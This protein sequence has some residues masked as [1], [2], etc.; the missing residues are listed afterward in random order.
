MIRNRARR[1]P[2]LSWWRVSICLLLLMLPGLLLADRPLPA[3]AAS[4]PDDPYPYGFIDQASGAYFVIQLTAAVPGYGHFSLALPGIGLLTNTAPAQIIASDPA[5]VQVTY[6]GAATLD[7]AAVLDS[8]TATF[9]RLSGQRSPVTIQLTATLNPALNT[10]TVMLTYNGQ[11]YTVSAVPPPHT[12][13]PVFTQVIT[14]FAQQDWTQMY[15]LLDSQWQASMTQADF[16]A[17]LSAG[18]P[19]FGT[20][21]DVQVLAAPDYATAREGYTVATGLVALTFTTN[22]AASVQWNYIVLIADGG[23]WK[24]NTFVPVPADTLAVTLGGPYTVAAG[25]SLALA[26]TALDPAGGTVTYSWDLD[27]DGAF[28]TAGQNVVYAAG[29]QEPT[30]RTIGVRATNG[31]GQTATGQTTVTVTAAAHYFDGRGGVR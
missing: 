7:G 17:W 8:E 4:A 15:G 29:P 6:D 20:L 28:E 21:T 25:E 19:A 18:F 24:L 23:Q 16:V 5:A 27:G 14:I 11:Q 31:S 12:A 10:G 3:A 26:A 22:G 13:E 2:R 9:T 30:S 1:W